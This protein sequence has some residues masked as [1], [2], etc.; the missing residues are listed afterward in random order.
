[1]DDNSTSPQDKHPTGEDHVPLKDDTHPL[2]FCKKSKKKPERIGRYTIIR[3]LGRGSMGR[4]YLARDPGLDRDVAIK[5]MIAGEDASEHAI[6]RFALEARSYGKLQHP[7]IVGVHEIS[8]EGAV[9][10][11]VMDYIRGRTLRELMFEKRLPFNRSAEIIRGVAFALDFVHEIGIVHRD[12]KPGNIIVRDDGSI[13]L[14]DFGLARN[15]QSDSSLTQTGQIVGTPLYLSPE[16]AE[17]EKDRIDVR[18]DIYSLGAVFYEM[19]TENPPVEGDSLL[20]I[21][22]MVLEEEPPSPTSIDPSIPRDLEIICRKAMFKE[23]ENRYQTAGKLADDLTRFLE[24]KLIAARPPTVFYWLSKAVTR[25]RKTLIVSLV[26]LLLSGLGILYQ[27]WSARQDKDRIVEEKDRIV[28]EKQKAEAR[29]HQILEKIRK[30]EKREWIAIYQEN[31]NQRKQLSEEWK[32]GTAGRIRNQALYIDGSTGGTIVWLDKPIIGEE[33]KFE[34]DG[35][36]APEA[37]DLNDI[38]LY[39]KADKKKPDWESGFEIQFGGKKNVQSG[40]FH[41]GREIVLIK[42]PQTIKAGHKYHFEIAYRNG[43]LSYT[44]VDLTE[45]KMVID[46]KKKAPDINIPEDNQRQ[47][48]WTWGS[49]IYIDNIVIS[50][51]G[52]PEK[53]DTLVVAEELWEDFGAETSVKYLINHIEEE[54]RYEKKREYY[55]KALKI[56]YNSSQTEQNKLRLV[57]SNYYLKIFGL[58]VPSEVMDGE[59]FEIFIQFFLTNAP[60][61][62]KELGVYPLIQ[63]DTEVKKYM[64]R[65]KAEKRGRGRPTKK[66]LKK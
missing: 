16:Q 66:P 20:R 13:C 52:S 54:T 63:Q 49:R 15:L 31:F 50:K 36:A 53:K 51:P 39:V 18:S 12:I 41:Q 9:Y 2:N 34:Y 43:E 25:N 37:S 38:G 23:P 27:R 59:F 7:D 45:E 10:Y 33:W 17:G 3:E 19:L 28:E 30:E 32:T 48:F 35:W 61:G 60:A 21:I 5:T 47:G 44:A 65:L 40:V 4:V 46:L 56:T 22:H 24:H 64:M 58:K 29:T 1:M 26:L 57:L 14:M 6:E 62:K 42:Q 8:R 11:M 55:L